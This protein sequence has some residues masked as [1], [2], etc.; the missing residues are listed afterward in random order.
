MKANKEQESFTYTKPCY[1]DSSNI[2]FT[3]SMTQ[4]YTI[5][6]IKHSASRWICE[7]VLCLNSIWKPRKGNKEYLNEKR[8]IKNDQKTS[9]EMRK[10]KCIMD[11]QK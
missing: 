6:N 5:L 4:G 8:D 1:N 9:E 3:F 10:E 7:D 2:M 11:F